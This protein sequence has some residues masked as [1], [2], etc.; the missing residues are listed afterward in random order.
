MVGIDATSSCQG[1]A[2]EGCSH[3]C[4]GLQGRAGGWR[5]I[6]KERAGPGMDGHGK[7]FGDVGINLGD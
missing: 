2:P 4:P 3:H 7:S 1:V 5:H 6:P